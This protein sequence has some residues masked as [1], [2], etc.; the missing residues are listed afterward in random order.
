MKQMRIWLLIASLVVPALVVAK[1]VETTSGIIYIQNKQYEE[2]RVILLKAVAKN[3]KDGEGNFYLALAYSELD[4]V[5]QA[6]KYFNIAKELEPKKARDIANNIQSNYARHYKLAQNAWGRADF[7]NAATEFD[8][9][10][11][12]DPTQSGA[13]YNLAVAYSRLALTDSTCDAKALAEADKV[14]KTG[15]TA[16]PNYTKSL[17]LASRTLARMGREDEAVERFKPLIEKD[18]S[19]YPMVEEI[20]MGLLEDKKYK[21]AEDFLLMSADARVKLGADSASTFSN[22]GVAAFNQRSTDPAKIDEAIGYYQK[23]LDRDPDNAPTAF[24]LIVACMAKQDWPA[25]ASWGEKY[26]SLKPSDAQGW[27]LLA[28][29]YSEAGDTDKATE[30]LKQFQTLQGQ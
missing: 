28:R 27:K 6:Y 17:Q 14:L 7:A 4:S 26:V 20:G 24:N 9:A 29:C 1:S 12:A 15:N 16:D 10:T 18:P 30:A 5:A 22:L 21:A 3:P 11:Q 25:G 23:A 19:K 8:L 13:H 2:A